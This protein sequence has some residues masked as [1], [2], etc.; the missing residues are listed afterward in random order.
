MGPPRSLLPAPR[1]AR[2]RR[3]DARAR[4]SDVAG[5]LRLA[6]RRSLT[7]RTPTTRAARSWRSG[8]LLGHVAP[9]RLVPRSRGRRGCSW[10]RRHL[11]VGTRLHACAPRRAFRRGDPG[12]A[13]RRGPR[14]RGGRPGVVVASGRSGDRRVDPGALRRAGC[15]RLRT[16]RAVPHRRGHRGAISERGGRLRRR[17]GPRR[18]RL[19]VRGALR[20]SR[21][22]RLDR[23]HRV[24]AV[25]ED[26]RSRDRGAHR[27]LRSSSRLRHRSS[28]RGTS[29]GAT[30]ISKSSAHFPGRW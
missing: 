16:R 27:A 28:T 1:P 22:A 26:P 3:L 13:R 30:A 10:V 8:A 25:V 14:G 11:D 24:P 17:L 6:R 5:S 19:G 4:G 21:R 15:V 9:R 20:S 23:A 2:H 18:C 12:D 29:P 7:E